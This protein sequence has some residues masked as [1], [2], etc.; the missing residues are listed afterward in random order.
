MTVTTVA[1]TLVATR[2]VL[3]VSP[4]VAAALLAAGAVA[5]LLPAEP[6]KSLLVTRA[7]GLLIALGVMF[8]FD[9]PAAPV[10]D[11]VPV[12]LPVRAGIG[13]ALHAVVAAGAWGIV[14][15]VAASRGSG[16]VP[17]GR[18]TFEAAVMVAVGW[19]IACWWRRRG[20]EDRPGHVAAGAMTLLFLI[21]QQLPERVAI[22]AAGPHDP[23]W[24]E[25]LW[26]LAALGAVATA[27]IAAGVR[28]LARTRNRRSQEQP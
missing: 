23:L 9:D 22:F 28:D 10:T 7:A 8:V 1:R 12:P 18:V 16:Q 14:M 25:T 24:H 27:A 17:I 26:R 11:A 15:L 6:A 19:A 5:V 13:V 20:G 2:R 3:P 21:A 4:A